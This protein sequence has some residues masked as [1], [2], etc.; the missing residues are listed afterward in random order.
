[1]RECEFSPADFSRMTRI[2][3]PTDALHRVT[4]GTNQACKGKHHDG[5][6]GKGGECLFGE[7][8]PEDL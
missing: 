7:G 4:A 8:M 3:Y 6:P 1:M 2:S 5:G